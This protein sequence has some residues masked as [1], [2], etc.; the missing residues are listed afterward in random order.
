MVQVV[1]GVV[2]K[3]GR[4]ASFP[5]GVSG[6]LD[7]A[8]LQCLSGSRRGAPRNH[9]C[10]YRQRA[11]GHHHPGTARTHRSGTGTRWGNP[12]SCHL[13][14]PRYLSLHLRLSRRHR[15]GR[16]SHR[17]AVCVLRPNS[18]HSFATKRVSC[19]RWPDLMEPPSL[20]Q[21]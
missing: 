16:R 1:W 5:A 8:F 10:A 7:A 17:P 20:F 14:E 21:R 15:H 2:P 12:V 19:R 13:Y 6:Y 4:L 9:Q 11:L 3:Y 18:G